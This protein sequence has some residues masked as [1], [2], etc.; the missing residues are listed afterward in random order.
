MSTLLF[1]IGAEE[2]PPSELPSVLA[3]LR[4]AAIQAVHDQDVEPGK[5]VVVR[6]R[7][8]VVHAVREGRHIHDVANL[9]TLPALSVHVYSPALTRRTRYAVAGDRL[10][11]TG[12]ERA[13]EHW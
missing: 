6:R 3:A 11:R 2:L 13:G 5:F 4:E 9:G 10:E 12:L 8:A 7:H 1:E